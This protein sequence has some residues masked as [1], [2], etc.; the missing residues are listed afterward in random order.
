MQFSVRASLEQFTLA[1]PFREGLLQISV[2]APAVKAPDT[3]VPVLY[4]VDGDILFGL[5]AEVARTIAMA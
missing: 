3:A 2:A 5:A 1:H 4:V